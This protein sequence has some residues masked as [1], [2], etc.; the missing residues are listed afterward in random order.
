MIKIFRILKIIFLSFFVLLGMF[1]FAGNTFLGVGQKNN[2]FPY[3]NTAFSE[4][5][6]LEKWERVESKMT[7]KEVLDL[8][9][10]PLFIMQLREGDCISNPNNALFRMHYSKEND[11][12]YG[13]FAWYSFEIFFDKNE[14]VV[15][16]HSVCWED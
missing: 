12:V 8:L 1:Y 11:H 10:E 15:T 16:K 5:F 2:F 7:K 4:G 9:G 3:I 6:N 14:K 13:K